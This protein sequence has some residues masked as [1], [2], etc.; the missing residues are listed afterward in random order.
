MRSIRG[1][2]LM[3][4]T[5]QLQPT[6]SCNFLHLSYPHC[7][8]HARSF[9]PPLRRRIHVCQKQVSTAL[10]WFHSNYMLPHLLTQNKISMNHTGTKQSSPNTNTWLLGH[11]FYETQCLFQ[12]SIDKHAAEDRQ[13][14]LESVA[15][16][17]ARNQRG[18]RNHISKRHFIKCFSCIKAA[19]ALHIHVYKCRA[20]KNP[21]FENLG[22]D[23]YWICRTRVR[24]GFKKNRESVFVGSQTILEHFNELR[25]GCIV[26]GAQGVPLEHG[27]PKRDAWAFDS[28]KEERGV[29]DVAGKR[30][31][32]GT[33]DSGEDVG[34]AGEASGDEES[35][36]LLQKAKGCA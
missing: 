1:K 17:I 2:K 21:D 26:L 35:M 10:L 18:P 16:D 13:S 34:I 31:G 5:I 8:P 15:L 24:E 28:M 20:N 27:I 6:A 29:I 23:L 7:L 33:E 12:M 30:K 32:G 9:L 22:V 11:A 19:A 3:Q 25:D 4:Y 36:D 14:F